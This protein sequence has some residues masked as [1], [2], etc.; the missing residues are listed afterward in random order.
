MPEKIQTIALRVHKW[1]GHKPPPPR[2][3][4]GLQILAPLAVQRAG[5][6]DETA[7]HTP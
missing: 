1:L 4:G 5:R 7:L 6:R 2:L 3:F